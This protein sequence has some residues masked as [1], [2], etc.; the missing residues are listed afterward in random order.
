MVSRQYVVASNQ[1]FDALHL[2]Y[3]RIYGNVSQ[4]LTQNIREMP[5]DAVY[6]NNCVSLHAHVYRDLMPKSIE[7]GCN[8]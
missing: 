8:R 2:W 5:L 1:R 6:H 4:L 7:Q 3:R